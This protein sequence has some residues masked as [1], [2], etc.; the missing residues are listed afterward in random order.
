MS[1]SDS[2]SPPQLSMSEKIFHSRGAMSVAL[3]FFFMFVCWINIKITAVI[4][5]L[6]FIKEISVAHTGTM[7]ANDNLM[8]RLASLV[9][10]S[11][12]TF[13]VYCFLINYQKHGLMNVSWLCLICGACDSSQYLVGRKIGMTK[14]FAY[15]PKKSLEGYIGGMIIAGCFIKFMSP[16]TPVISTIAMLICMCAGDA[17]CSIWKRIVKLKDFSDLMGAHGGFLDRLDS[18]C[19]LQLFA[20]IVMDGRFNCIQERGIMSIVFWIVTGVVVAYFK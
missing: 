2:Q 9:L 3:I 8:K 5:W 15:S 20:H 17:V 10:L 13:C 7:A 14:I 11:Y 12:L 16:S 1:K 18:Q 6:I 4:C 19:A